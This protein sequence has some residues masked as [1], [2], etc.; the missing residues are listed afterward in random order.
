MVKGIRRKEFNS[1]LNKFC[2]RSR[3]F[4]RPHS[5]TNGD[6]CEVNLKR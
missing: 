2:T 1:K 4:Y 6:I 3:P 5:E